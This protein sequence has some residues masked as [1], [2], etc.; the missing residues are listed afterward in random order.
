MKC[1]GLRPARRFKDFLW[2]RSIAGAAADGS[3]QGRA[4][5]GRGQSPLRRD[6]P[7][8]SATD[9]RMPTRTAVA[10][11]RDG[12]PHQG[13][14]ARSH[15]RPHVGRLH[16]GQPAS[17][18]VR[19]DATGGSKLC[20]ASASKRQSSPCHLRLDPPQAPQDRR[21]G[22]HLRPPRQDRH[23]LRPSLAARR[24]SPTPRSAPHA[25][26]N[27]TAHSL[28]QDVRRR[29]QRLPKLV[30]TSRKTSCV[31]PSPSLSRD[32]VKLDRL[33]QH[34]EIS[35]S[36]LTPGLKVALLRHGKGRDRSPPQHRKRTSL[37]RPR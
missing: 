10:P 17:P 11:A 26:T 18:V 19:L 29:S 20:A 3:W 15:R 6:P 16:A 23:G 27:Q 32:L 5:P 7:A 31:A 8:N 25:D 14:P 2:T 24:R 34:R 9:A 36:V 12:E 4:Y 13:M 37:L 35:G 1:I 28:H 33:T 21:V 30:R 22:P